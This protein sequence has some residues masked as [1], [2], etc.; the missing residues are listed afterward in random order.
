MVSSSAET[1]WIAHAVDRAAALGPWELHQQLVI[2]DI[3]RYVTS[4]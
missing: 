2:G 1:A 3:G 4:F